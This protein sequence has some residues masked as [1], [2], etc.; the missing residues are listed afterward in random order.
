MQCTLVDPVASET[1]QMGRD[2]GDRDRMTPERAVGLPG[3]PAVARPSRPDRTIAPGGAAPAARHLPIVTR[4]GRELACWNCNHPP[5]RPKPVTVSSAIH[6]AP[7]SRGRMRRRGPGSRASG[8][9]RPGCSR[10]DRRALASCSRGR[11]PHSP[12]AV[13]SGWPVTRPCRGGQLVDCDRAWRRLLVRRAG[14]AAVPLRLTVISRAR[15][16]P[17][18]YARSRVAR[19]LRPVSA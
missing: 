7:V 1:A 15:P 19:S 14:K 8:R 13:G 4:S 11:R 5:T 9:C 12:E 17:P 16:E 18:W 10:G 3:A 2:R 6:R